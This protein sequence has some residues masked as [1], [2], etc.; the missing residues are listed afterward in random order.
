MGVNSDGTKHPF[1][2]KLRKICLDLPDTKLTMTWGA[3]HFRVANKIFCGSGEEDG[4]F[5]IGFKLEK[6][7]AARVLK[8]P[9]FSV[10]PYVGKHGWVHMKVTRAKDLAEVRRYVEESYELI[11][12]TK[13]LAKLKTIQ[14][15]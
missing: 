1:F 8:D 13:S 3:P 6:P 2:S 10:A 5:T 15:K 9:R 11:A 12:P 14:P 7:H 4:V